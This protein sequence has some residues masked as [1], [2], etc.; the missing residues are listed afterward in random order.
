MEDIL[1]RAKNF[2]EEAEVF[3]ASIEQ[4]PVVFETNRL[5]QLHTQQSTVTTL[6]IIHHGKIGLATAAGSYD[7]EKLVE[8]AIALAE[9]GITSHVE[10]PSRQRYPVVELYD[11]QVE[12]TPVN[13][14]IVLGQS[15]IDHVRFHTPELICQAEVSKSVISV[16]IINSRGGD[17][18][19][20]KSIFSLGMEGTL[21]RG[22]DML[23]VFDSE[24]SCHNIKDAGKVSKT[25]TRQLE[26]ARNNTVVCTGRLPVIFTS[27]GMASVI[28]HPLMEAFNGKTVLQGASPLGDKQGVK[29]FDK[30][31]N[32]TDDATVIHRPASY[33][34]DDEG[35]PGQI[36]SLV[37]DGV[38]TN[39]IYDLQT[40]G[41]A[42]TRS[43]GNGDRG[44]GGMPVPSMSNLVIAPGEV[45]FEDMIRD[46]KEGLVV[47]YLMGAD[48]GNVLG[49]EFS[50]NVLL[51][52]KV[53]KGEIV[54]R[55]K[56]TMLSGNIYHI[57]KNINAIGNK[58]EWAGSLRTPAL[59]CAD[60][61]V[62]CKT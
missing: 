29:V 18:S 39:F 44:S 46:M 59:L 19:Y 53:E 33:P 5:K 10:F 32:V 31:I 22:E 48:Q 61:A 6:R 43:T 3:R 52:Y 27:L 57:L 34:S 45:S 2:A 7:A 15:L 40:A 28:A 12:E 23:F 14:M 17:I 4:T 30:K 58:Q 38:V 25:I 20:R 56:D 51:G 49:G 54:G 35:T 55:V 26:W 36:T 24:S 47:E 60:L 37:E 8:R 50:G 13:Q 62:T 21:V 11:Y 9:M 16:R 1:A 41:L 42:G